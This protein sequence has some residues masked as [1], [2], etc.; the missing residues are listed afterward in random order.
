VL[1]GQ[2][3]HD[4]IIKDKMRDDT[5]R[6]RSG[7]CSRSWAPASTWP[8][9]SGPCARSRRRRKRWARAVSA[10]MSVEWLV[11]EQRAIAQL[12]ELFKDQG[13]PIVVR[14]LAE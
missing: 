13:L 12:E 9:R 8:P 11:S 1:A 4:E 14:F 10:G 7:S 2:A 5:I 3:I 6:R